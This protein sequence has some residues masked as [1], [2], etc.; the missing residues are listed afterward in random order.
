[1]LRTKLVLAFATCLAVV[2]VMA[3]LLFWGPERMARTLDRSLLAHRQAEGY[4][5][6]SSEAYRHF[7]QLADRL[8]AAEVAQRTAI[9][10]RSAARASAGSSRSSSG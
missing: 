6:L 10:R 9:R 1:M 5:R 7:W 2:F 8:I 4:L 3:A